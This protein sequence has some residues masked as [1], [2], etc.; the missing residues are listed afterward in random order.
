MPPQQ[1]QEPG[2]VRLVHSG[3]TSLLGGL[4]PQPGAQA[5][6]TAPAPATCSPGTFCLG[7]SSSHPSR[8]QALNGIQRACSKSL[9]EASLGQFRATP[10]QG[11]P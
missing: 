9:A 10:S 1:V 4:G 8:G 5:S 11:S 7:C 2:V 6:H 3:K